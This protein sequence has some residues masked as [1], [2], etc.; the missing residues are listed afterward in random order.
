MSIVLEDLCFEVGGETRIHQIN[1]TL[2]SGFFKM[3]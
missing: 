2:E 3:T 1:L